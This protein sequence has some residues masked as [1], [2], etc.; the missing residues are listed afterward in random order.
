MSLKDYLLQNTFEL[1]NSASIE[2]LNEY[3]V[4]NII[5]LGALI[6]NGYSYENLIGNI[7]YLSNCK[8]MGTFDTVVTRHIYIEGY[9]EKD[10]GFENHI[11]TPERMICDFIMY[12]EE[13]SA[14]LWVHN[15]II[16]Y[17]EDDETPN[18]FHLI[19]EMLDHFGVDRSLFDKRV[20][21]LEEIE[22]L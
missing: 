19:Y 22:E 11:A 9:K 17:I 8:E 7:T 4:G 2:D 13:L 5:G 14:D 10:Y 20:E 1:V 15:A 6:L 16:G 12:P 18:D 3:L 21:E